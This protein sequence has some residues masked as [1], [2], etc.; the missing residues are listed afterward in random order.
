MSDL[1]SKFE[2]HTETQGT[3]ARSS[4]KK[5]QERRGFERDG[6]SI[7]VNSMGRVERWTE[8]ARDLWE[9]ENDER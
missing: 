9:M 3:R 7:T 2:R 6:N 4:L 8:I 1:E 5:L